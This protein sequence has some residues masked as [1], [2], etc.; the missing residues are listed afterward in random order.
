MTPSFSQSTEATEALTS[1]G[2][3][4]DIGLTREQNEDSLVVAA[5]LF[6]VADGM[7]GHEA[8][9]V[10]SEIAVSAISE[11]AP[12]T[13][14]AEALGHAVEVANR[15]VI[16]ATLS[17]RGREGMGTTCTAAILEGNRLVIAQVGDSRAY[18]L[19]DG[20]LSQITRDHSLVADM[21]ESGQ[22][23]REQ[24]RYHPNRSVITRALGS[25]VNMQP[26][27]YEITIEEGDRV[28]LCSDG[29]TS[30]L[31]DEEIRDVMVANPDPQAC[32]EGLVEA[33][34]AAGGLDNVT[35]IVVKADD[36]RPKQQ[37]KMAR[38]TKIT[39]ACVL[40]AVVACIAL[41]VWGGMRYLYNS[42]YLAES[43]QGYVQ[44]YRGVPGE[45]LGFSYSL[46]VES[47][48]I[49][50][51]ELNSSAADNIRNNLRVGSLDEALDLVKSYREQIKDRHSAPTAGS[52]SPD[53]AADSNAPDALAGQ[54]AADATA[55]QDASSQQ[56][57]QGGGQ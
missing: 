26:D 30:M 2:S 45:V 32:A 13:A 48:D 31:L 40:V 28:L 36:A 35:V 7:G 16:D 8:G 37:R 11:Y 33:A 27:L 56:A 38:R 23:T 17:G 3:R 5:P 55:N 21:V 46:L 44:V 50:V 24:A 52:G 39:L 51:D 47:T 34:L 14:D 43:D 18:V 54:D 41:A 22:I 15:E 53:S 29:L 6:V 12:S 57:A 10:A 25:D 4:T 1:F 9:E 20:K 19:H 42:A 49:P